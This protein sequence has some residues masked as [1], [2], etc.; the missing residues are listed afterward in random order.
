MFKKKLTAKRISRKQLVLNK[1]PESKL[2][3]LRYLNGQWCI[4][5]EQRDDV[6]SQ[7]VL[8]A[9]GPTWPAERVEKFIWSSGRHITD[10][11]FCYYYCLLVN[12]AMLT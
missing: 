5:T 9:E 2:R 8:V 1:M 6:D 4:I 11:C 7:A 12:V 10:V 3:I